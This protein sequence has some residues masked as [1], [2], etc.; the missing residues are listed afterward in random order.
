LGTAKGA[1]AISTNKIYLSDAFISS[2][3]QQSLEAVILEEFGHFVDAQVNATD[4]LGDEGEL[5]SALVR[6]VSLSAAELGRIQAEDDHAIAVI[7]GQQVAIEQANPEFKANTYT[8]GDQDKANVTALAGGGFLVVWESTGQ[9][10]NL[11]GIYG[12]RYDNNQL[13]VGNEFRANTTITNNQRNPV[14][15]GLSGGGYVIAWQSTNQDGSFDGIYAQRFNSNGTLAGS[16]FQIN[17]QTVEN[18]WL[19]ALSALN[20]GGFVAVWQSWLQDGNNWGVFGQRFDSNGNPDGTEFQVNTYTT[21]NQNVV[22]V[23][24]LNDGSFVV[25]WESNGQ[26]SGTV[27]I[28]GQRFDSNGLALGSEFLINTYSP[29]NQTN[30]AISKLDNGGFVVVWESN[31]QDGS[32]LGIYGQR[33]DSNGSFV[34]SEFLVNTYTTNIQSA[35][36]VSPL[37]NGGFAVTWESLNQDGSSWGVYSKSFGGNGNPLNTEIRINTQT[38]NDQSDPSIA[39]LAGGKTVVLW[40]SLNQE[41]SASGYGIY[42]KV[43]NTPPTVQADKTIAVQIAPINLGITVP[44]DID[45]DPLTVT[46]GNIPDPTYGVIKLGATTI[47][48]GSV[49]LPSDLPNLVFEGDS[50][51][52]AQIVSSQNS[53]YTDFSYSVSDGSYTTTQAVALANLPPHFNYSYYGVFLS[54]GDGNNTNGEFVLSFPSDYFIDP[55]GHTLTYSFDSSYL[56]SSW[57]YFDV[58]NSK[59]IQINPVPP[60]GG[61]VYM[62]MTAT[63]NLG[64][65]GGIGLWLPFDDQYGIFGVCVDNYIAGA[66]VFFDVNNNGILDSGELSTTTDENGLY[67]LALPETLDLNSNGKLD[68]NEG[69]IV[70]F[71]GIDTATG[72]ALETP[73]RATPDATVV[74]LLS[75]VVAKLVDQGLTVAEA[76]T[77]LSNALS[78]P[79]DVQINSFDPI[80]A[81]KNNQAGGVA[82]FAAMV[83]V[84][85]LIT[86]I[87]GLLDGASSVANAQIVNNVVSAITNQIQSSNT[88]NLTNTTQLQAIIQSA[89]ISTGVTLSADRITGSAQIVAES[90]QRIDTLATNSPANTLE[91]GF[92]KVQKIALDG[93]TKD[94]KEVG[95]GTKTIADVVA[96]NTGAA[97]DTKI[98]NAKVFSAD[99]TDIALSNASI[100]ENQPINTSV[101]TLTS[102][103]PD[104]TNFTYSLVAGPGDTD[105]ALFTITGNQLRTNTIFDYETKNSYS[106]RVL[107]S[108]GDGGIYSEQL[109]ININDVKPTITLAVSPN[110]VSE[111]GATNLIYTF[112]RDNDLSNSL[113]INYT[114]SGTATNG[115]DYAPIGTIATFAP[116]SAT[117]IVTVNP[118]ADTTIEANE[119]VALTLAT[120]T[121]YTIGTATAVTGT[122]INDDT[123]TITLAVAPASV[124]EDGTPNLVYTFTRTGV[125]TNALTVNYYTTGTATNGTDYTALVGTA[126]FASNSATAIVTV[127][128]T[129]DTT[130]EANETVALTLATGTGYTIGT[131]TAVTGTIINDDTPTITLAVTP[132]SV[133][134]DGTS[135]LVYTFTRT[136]VTTNA[137]TVNYG[138]TGTATA[139]DY[140]GATPG[141]GK[142][143]TFAA[144]SATAIL[145]ID[146]TADVIF[147]ANE[148][149]ALTLATGTGYT[150]GTATAVTGTIINDDTPTITLAV[151]PASVLEDGTPNLVYTFTRTGPTTNALTVNYGITGTATNGTDYAAIGT[152]ATFAPNSATAIVTVN[153]TADTTIEANETVALTL[154][155]GTGYTIGTATAVTGTIINDD[156]PTITLAVAPASVLEDGTPNLVY[157]FTR[158]GPTTNALT[159]NYGITGTAT[160]GTDYATI[161]ITATFASNSATAI[162]T[163]NPTADT[164]IEANE[165]VALTLATGTGYTIGTTTAVTGT[166]INDDTNGV[167]FT[168]TI[169][170]D[171]LTGGAGNDTLIGGTGKDTLTGGTGTDKFVFTS[172]ADS[173][174]AGYDVISDYTIG[175]QIDAPPTVA[176]V[177]LN[178]SS[179]IAASLAA[180]D[181]SNALGGLSFLGNTAKAF[182]VTG[183][184]G[185]FLAFND[186]TAAFNAATDSIVQLSAYSISATNTVTIV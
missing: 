3:S 10:G 61:W 9:D 154:A 146:P 155:T 174:L 125:T 53:L 115:T 163:V 75:T 90:N 124:L 33:F 103:D 71:G 78:L 171:A 156:T 110:T 148:T 39:L 41:S 164:T 50:I 73:L 172:L 94:L 8:T 35:P 162:V 167:V 51:S 182:T 157:T 137:L 46:V 67:G 117:A 21:G 113:T 102:L 62:V 82:T 169:A 43:L 161:G 99:P 2:A 48:T 136:G 114:I 14:S 68:P 109:T 132:A 131:A 96:S 104:S 127:N 143:I 16:E 100:F 141:T 149:L 144:N 176:A 27:G 89:A 49:L 56:P 80:L 130:I 88:L 28:Y 6:G 70:A 63:D 126:T 20:N 4:T 59:L 18:Q 52:I 145:T 116:N 150:I 177:V 34:G 183:Q 19:P 64:L 111:D 175:E 142:T 152:T 158:T 79:A 36:S 13:P 119:T 15:V 121:G 185:T 179:G 147:E 22:D 120:G 57:V 128:P 47:T 44:T 24:T 170:N 140:T 118:T 122:I 86:Q 69:M 181:I 151:A 178:T 129:A 133:L 55:E 23:E 42:G 45:G 184:S 54:D 25:V 26:D 106:I 95:A 37:S 81:T 29:N 83:K 85:N 31:G 12:Q 186:A 7:D 138:I 165:T 123:P 107:T 17:T 168:G 72:L 66:T 135:N 65:N 11:D 74:T 153:P 139:T 58:S 84:Q 38:A 159:V 5:F 76:N 180:A 32:S 93:T 101:G 92:A 30:P 166:I 97:L 98:I 40:Q 105:N 134:E 77:K 91:Q 60:G 112:T 160:N 1:Y 173:L 87:T 108:D